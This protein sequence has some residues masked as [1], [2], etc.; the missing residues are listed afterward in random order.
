MDVQRTAAEVVVQSPGS[1]NVSVE[2]AAA[3]GRGIESLTVA[4]PPVLARIVIDYLGSGLFTIDLQALWD[5]Y[6]QEAEDCHVGRIIKFGA[7]ALRVEGNG[8]AIGISVLFLNQC[9]IMERS[10]Y[11][12]ITHLQ[13]PSK[14]LVMPASARP[15]VFPDETSP[16]DRL[17]IFGS[18]FQKP[19]EEQ[20]I[21]TPAKERIVVAAVDWITGSGAKELSIS[22]PD[23]T[24]AQL[25]NAF[26]AQ[27]KKRH[28]T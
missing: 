23:S 7:R 24:E 8:E 21:V 12:N 14:V 2:R 16:D 13:Q 26:V 20:I 4:L 27:G 18:R 17:R 10:F 19:I 11:C 1:E 25:F 22:M 5:S 6:S 3:A 9:K 15:F 28:S